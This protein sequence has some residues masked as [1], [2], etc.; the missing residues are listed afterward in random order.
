MVRT[1]VRWAS[2]FTWELPFLKVI[3]T[4]E[5]TQMKD[6]LIWM[7]LTRFECPR[8]PGTHLFGHVMFGFISWN[9][10][11]RRLK[12]QFSVKCL[13]LNSKIFILSDVNYF[14]VGSEQRMTWVA[15]RCTGKWDWIIR[16]WRTCEKLIL[17]KNRTRK[18]REERKS[19][20]RSA[21]IESSIF[22]RNQF[23]LIEFLQR[24]LPCLFFAPVVLGLPFPSAN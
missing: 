16:I 11:S 8:S 21:Q 19:G 6:N 7:H 20:T 10:S 4:N 17:I 18:G 2:H 9:H 24:C 22:I 23:S 15:Q 3:E 14:K 12:F 13:C 1:D 5:T